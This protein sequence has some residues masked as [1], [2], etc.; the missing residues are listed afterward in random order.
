MVKEEQYGTYSILMGRVGSTYIDGVS[1]QWTMP[2]PMVRIG[3][4]YYTDDESRTLKLRVGNA[5]S[6]GESGK[7][8]Y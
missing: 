4:V 6:V 8:L 5:Y 2:I 1:E 3:S 7:Y